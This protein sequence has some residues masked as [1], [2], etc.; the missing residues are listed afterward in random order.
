MTDICY[1]DMGEHPEAKQPNGSNGVLHIPC[2]PNSSTSS[3]TE[4]TQEEPSSRTPIIPRNFVWRLQGGRR[5]STSTN[6]TEPDQE[7]A[8]AAE[9]VVAMDGPI[10]G[11]LRDSFDPWNRQN[12][13][14]HKGG[15]KGSVHGHDNDDEI[16]KGCIKISR[17][18]AS[19]ALRDRKRA[20]SHGE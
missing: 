15:G 4:T 11:V 18:R 12:H 13:R 8:M 5:A 1:C 10:S 19:T 2:S 7:D 6:S 20:G 14:R 16:C 9:D 3:L 17:A